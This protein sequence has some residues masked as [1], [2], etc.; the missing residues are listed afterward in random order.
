MS[1]DAL[2]RQIEM[3]NRPK[4]AEPKLYTDVLTNYNLRRPLRR[5]YLKAVRNALVSMP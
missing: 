4:F 3:F 2:V 5:T 1:N